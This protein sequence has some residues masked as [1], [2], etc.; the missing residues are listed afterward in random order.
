MFE[1]VLRSFGRRPALS[2]TCCV[3]CGGRGL[4]AYDESLAILLHLAADRAAETSLFT[5]DEVHRWRLVTF[6]GADV[7]FNLDPLCLDHVSR[8]RFVELVEACAEQMRA[9]QQLPRDL[10]ASWRPLGREV[11]LHHDGLLIDTAPIVELASA[12][13]QRADST[14]PSPPTGSWWYFGAPGGPEPSR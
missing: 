10:V 14:L 5:D 1:I 9:V 3:E 11:I 12:I 13:V 2:K 4:W 7:G 8:E 6:L